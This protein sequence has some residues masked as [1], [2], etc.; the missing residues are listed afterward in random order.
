MRKYLVL[1]LAL[2]LFGCSRVEET[3]GITIEISELS[4]SPPMSST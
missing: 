3:P 1:A 4:P 2:A